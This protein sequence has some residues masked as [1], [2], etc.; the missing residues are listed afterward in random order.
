MCTFRLFDNFDTLKGKKEGRKEGRKKEGRKEG[1]EGGTKEGRKE[2][3]KDGRTEGRMDGQAGGRMENRAVTLKLICIFVFAYIKC[4][5]SHYAA[6]VFMHKTTLKY[7]YEMPRES[8]NI[9]LKCP[10]IVFPLKTHFYIE[11]L[12]FTGVFIFFSNFCSK[13]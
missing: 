8:K 7:L 11:K 5:F 12:G 1:R 9:M 3:R 10:C 13:T 6:Q 4:W 2:G